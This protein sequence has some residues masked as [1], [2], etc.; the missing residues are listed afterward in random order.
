MSVMIFFLRVPVIGAIIVVFLEVCDDRKS[1]KS[2]KEEKEERK[3]NKKKKEK[4][5]WKFEISGK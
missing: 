5:K 2:K 4:R 1:K 3:K